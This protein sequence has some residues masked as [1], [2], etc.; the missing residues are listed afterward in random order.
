[1]QV[2]ERHFVETL[3]DYWT[4]TLKLKI[5]IGRGNSSEPKGDFPDFVRAAVA[6]YPNSILKASM[7]ND[8]Q[9]V[10]IGSLNGHIRRA[11]NKKGR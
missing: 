2:P 10:T 7:P 3:A 8:R 1:M 11:A 4:E 5:R 9:H 6:L